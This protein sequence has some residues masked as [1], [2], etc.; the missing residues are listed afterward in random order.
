MAGPDLPFPNNVRTDNSLFGGA[1]FGRK[2]RTIV[3]L[4]LVV[5]FFVLWFNSGLD[6]SY[7]D[8]TGVSTEEKTTSDTTPATGAPL[9]DV[10]DEEEEHEEEEHEESLQEP[11]AVTTETPKT[12]ANSVTT[13]HMQPQHFKYFIVIAS[14]TSHQSR[15]Q[16]IRNT[17]FGL[18]DN[19]EPCMKRD[20]GVNYMFWVYGD[21]PEAKTPERRLY[22]TEKME[23]NDL[24]KVDA[25]SFKQDEVLK[26]VNAL[27][28]YV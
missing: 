16:L 9:N 20:K 17:Y 7:N 22:E 21:E 13:I 10:P 1:R 18:N 26:W 15:R 14:R 19:V 25:K 12:P 24:E 6:H 27:L 23:W 11:P 8:F 5:V 2:K 28:Q 3:L 4:L